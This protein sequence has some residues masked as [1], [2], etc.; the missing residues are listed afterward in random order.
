MFVR[1]FK[2]FMRFFYDAYVFLSG[3]TRFLYGSFMVL[4]E[5]L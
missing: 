4:F 3:F 5:V 2:I 1:L